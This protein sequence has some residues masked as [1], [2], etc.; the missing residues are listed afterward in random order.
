MEQIK[1]LPIDK[2]LALYDLLKPHLSEDKEREFLDL[3]EKIIDSMKESNPATY[4]HCL[5]LLSGLELN[6]FEK[7]NS[8]EA[9]SIFFEGLMENNVLGLISFCENL[10]L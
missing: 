9:F 5:Q 4:V 7:I 8:I 3:I 2:A 6:D 1:M 10:G